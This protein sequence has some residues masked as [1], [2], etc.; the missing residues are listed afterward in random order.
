MER[1]TPDVFER[2]NGLGD[3]VRT[4]LGDLF[5]RRGAPLSVTGVGSLFNIHATSET[6]WSNRVVQRGERQVPARHHPGTDDEGLLAC[7]ARH[8]LHL[9]ANARGRRRRPGGRARERPRRDVK[10]PD[11]L[12]CSRPERSRTLYT[13]SMFLPSQPDTSEL[14][15]PFAPRVS[16]GAMNALHRVLERNAG[17]TRSRSGCNG[18]RDCTRRSRSSSAW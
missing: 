10:P 3:R 14:P 9:H 5:E 12:L 6:V 2:L 15:R 8:G 1:L 16:A 13:Y 4:N 17:G 11:R 7:A 18:P